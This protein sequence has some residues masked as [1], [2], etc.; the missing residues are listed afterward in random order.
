MNWSIL[1]TRLYGGLWHTTHPAR[2]K[3]IFIDG[4]LLPEPNISDEERWKTK[5]GPKNYPF[6]RKIGGVSLFDF[7]QFDPTSYSEN[8][9]LSSWYEF[10]PHRKGW[11]GAIWIEIDRRGVSKQFV[12]ASSIVEK[13]KSTH[14]YGNTIMPHLEAAHLGKLESKF[15]KSAFFTWSMGQEVRDV[16]IRHFSTT[17]YDTIFNEWQSSQP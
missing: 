9:P 13:W 11:G 3:Q 10:V 1:E 6:V 17:T 14:S 2:L 7:D 16:D 4:G 12:T 15:F 8:Y 5:N